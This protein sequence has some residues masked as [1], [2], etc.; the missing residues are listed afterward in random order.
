MILTEI[1]TIV[2]GCVFAFHIIYNNCTKRIAANN[3]GPTHTL[4]CNQ[5]FSCF[6]VSSPRFS[7]ITTNKNKTM[8]APAYKMI[9]SNAT[10]DAPSVKNTTEVARKE[11]MRYNKACM[12]LY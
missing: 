4:G 6:A 9:C 3:D 7:I 11:T 2:M 12:G 10:N 8:I 1:G 5:F